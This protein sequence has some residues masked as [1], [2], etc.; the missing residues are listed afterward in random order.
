MKKRT[1]FFVLVM[2]TTF[3]NA[4]TTYRHWISASPG[5]RLGGSTLAHIAGELRY[6]YIINPSFSV[7]AYTYYEL[8]FGTGI[9]GRWYPSSKS[10]FFE[11]GLGYN[12][13]FGNSIYLEHDTDKWIDFKF[14]Y[15]GIEI[16]P[17]IGWRINIGKP[18]GLF[19]TPS[20]RYPII[21]RWYKTLPFSD[22]PN[23]LDPRIHTTL[24]V[25]F[26]FGYA[27]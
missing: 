10:F 7:G 15:N 27:F 6:E 26:G 14:D 25:Y 17:G 5:L 1:L 18:G 2:C 11:V 16:V 22:N 20:V 8:S 3:L 13:L 19:I 12:K 24:I 21:Y 4:Q 9:S 23:T